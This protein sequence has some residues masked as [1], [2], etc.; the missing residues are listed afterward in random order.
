MPDSQLALWRLS[1]SCVVGSIA[2][3]YLEIIEF[4]SSWTNF[5]RH[6]LIVGFPEIMNRCRIGNVAVV[7]FRLA[8]SHRNGQLV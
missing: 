2:Q 6:S 5:I 1:R 7:I 3:R 8:S 4:T